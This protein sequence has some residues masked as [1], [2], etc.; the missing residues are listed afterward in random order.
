MTTSSRTRWRRFRFL[1]EAAERRMIVPTARLSVLAAACA[2]MIAAGYAAGAGLASLLLANGLLIILSVLDLL[3]LPRRKRLSFARSLPERA[4]RNALFE[5][6]LTAE[7]DRPESLR[8]EFADDIPLS[9]R[10]PQGKLTADWSGKRAEVRYATRGKERGEYRFSFVR[11][12]LRGRLGLW[13]KQTKAELE[14]TVR[15]YPDMSGARGILASRDK[16]LV[17]EGKAI[18]RKETS[19]SEFHAVREYTPDDDLRMVNWR[20]TARSRALMTNVYRPERGKT[21]MILIDCGRMMGIEL[22]GRTKLDASLEAALSLAAVALKQGDKVGLVAF[23]NRIKAYVPPGTGLVHLSVLTDAVFNAKSDFVEASYQTA[24]HYLMRVHKKSCLA[25]L[26]S[27]MDNYMYEE[28][29]RPLLIR[30]QRQHQL[31]LLGLRDEVLH[32]WTLKATDGRR[33]A[34]AKSLSH[35]FALGRQRHTA[36]MEADGIEAVDVPAG[37][38]AWTAVN[39]YLQMKAKDAL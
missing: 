21:V 10:Q 5:V 36:S 3:L 23:S 4:D 9:F 38:L 22:D 16:H 7:S 30:A 24:I 29:L 28:G 13:M 35:Q 25:V 20:A 8:I 15:I 34:F 37:E 1:A 39:R 33:T 27:D 14:Q 26:F 31:L 6:V 2:L 17:L 19:G 12:R 11:V 18:Y 32:E